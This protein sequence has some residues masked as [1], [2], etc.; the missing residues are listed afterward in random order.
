LIV[1]AIAAILYRG[2]LFAVNSKDYE[3]FSTPNEAEKREQARDRG[4]GCIRG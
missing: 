2:I 4:P 3:F 1:C